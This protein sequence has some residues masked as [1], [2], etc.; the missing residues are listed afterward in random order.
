MSILLHTCCGPCACY[1]TKHLLEEGLQPTLYFYN[2]NIHPYQEQKLRL[3]GFRRLAAYRGLPALVEPGYELEE[4]LKAV[5]VDPQKRCAEC[6][7]IRLSRTAAK[8]KEL[9]FELFGTTLLISPY[10]NRE[11]I[12]ETGHGLARRYG[13]R[14]YDADFRPGFRES[15]NIAKELGLYRQK[16]C[17]CIYSEKERY[18]R[19]G[20]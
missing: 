10:Q 8:A 17:G 3:E 12:C 1:T 15:Q 9:G 5:A 2:P 19:E 20:R 16:Y 18:Y 7:R 11:L 13:L 4:F 14:F 6:Y